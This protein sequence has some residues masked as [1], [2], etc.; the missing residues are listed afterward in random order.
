[1]LDPLINMF[2]LHKNLT[3]YYFLTTGN[4]QSAI[5]QDPVRFADASST[6]SSVNETESDRKIVV[7]SG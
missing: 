7:R 6:P 5:C 1:M 4:P 3:L 2:D